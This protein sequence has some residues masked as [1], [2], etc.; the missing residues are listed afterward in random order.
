MSLLKSENPNALEDTVCDPFTAT[1]NDYPGVLT[2]IEVVQT[3]PIKLKAYFRLPNSNQYISVEGIAGYATNVVPSLP[4]L[5]LSVTCR[6]LNCSQ[7]T[8]RSLVSLNPA[9]TTCKFTCPD[10]S[11]GLQQ[12]GTILD[13]SAIRCPVDAMSFA[14]CNFNSLFPSTIRGVTVIC[15][16]CGED[17]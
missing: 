11:V 17:P 7:V 2:R 1:I 16:E 10:G 9:G 13:L 15:S 5:A 4:N 12:C 3:T 6:S 14:E 8:G